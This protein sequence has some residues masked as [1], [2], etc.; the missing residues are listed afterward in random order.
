MAFEQWTEF[1]FQ[2]WGIWLESLLSSWPQYSWCS[3]CVFWT[4]L[5]SVFPSAVPLQAL[6]DPYQS[7]PSSSSLSGLALWV[8]SYPCGNS[9]VWV[10]TMKT[11]RDV[12][13]VDFIN[14]LAVVPVSASTLCMDRGL[15]EMSLESLKGLPWPKYFIY[16]PC[17][18][19]LNYPNL[20]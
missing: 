19:S 12:H 10:L 17:L 6:P 2:L 1:H 11:L 20:N 4:G 9:R 15:Y 8:P 5:A 14:S 18:W 13:Q 3:R 7:N 16:W